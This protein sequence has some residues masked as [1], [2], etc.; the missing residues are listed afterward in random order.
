M[1]AVAGELGIGPLD[2]GMAFDARDA[3]QG[4]ATLER[5]FPTDNVATGEIGEDPEETR[6][7]INEVRRKAG[8][9]PIED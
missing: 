2:L 6:R 3:M 8:M 9:P 4:E 1:R 7:K 5:D